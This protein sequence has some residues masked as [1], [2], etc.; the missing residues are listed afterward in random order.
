MVSDTCYKYGE[1]RIE[2]MIDM[3]PNTDAMFFFGFYIYGVSNMDNYTA[4]N[5][6]DIGFGN[7]PSKDGIINY[8]PAFFSPRE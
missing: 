8:L 4:W 6:I 5:E 1:M 3:S 2:A 7:G